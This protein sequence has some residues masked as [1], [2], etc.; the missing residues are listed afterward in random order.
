MAFSTARAFFQKYSQQICWLL[1]LIFLFFMD[2]TNDAPSFCLFKLA[3]FSSCPGCGIGHAIHHTLHLRFSES[4]GAH[5]LGI[6]ATIGILCQLILSFI[7]TQ[8]SRH[9]PWTNNNC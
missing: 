5:P 7:Q 8:K 3:G 4:F 2:A 1:A 9:L 6:P